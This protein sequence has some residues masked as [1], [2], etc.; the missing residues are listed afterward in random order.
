[1]AGGSFLASLVAGV[2]SDFLGRHKTIQ[3]S[4]FIWIVGAAIQCSSSTQAQL[5]VGRVVA[6]LGVGFASTQVPVYVAELSPKNIRGRLVGL[7]QFSVTIGILVQYAIAYGAHFLKTQASFRLAWGIQMVPGAFMMLGMIFTPES[8]R[9]LANKDRWEEAI[10]IV[11]Q[12]QGKGDLNNPQVLIEIEEL[13]EQVRIDRESQSFSFFDLF[14]KG[15][16][17]RT[18]VGISAQIWQQL[19]GMNVMMYYIVYIFMMAGYDTDDDLVPSIIQ[20]ALNVVMTIPA[21]LFIDKVGRRP[22]LLAGGVLMTLWL[23][24][25]TG[26]LAT[27]SHWVP[28]VGGNENINITISKDHQSASQAVIAC[29][30]L[31]V[32]SFAPTWGPGIWLYC[33]EIFPLKQRAMGSAVCG[34]FNWL[35]NFGIA[36]WTPVG[37]HNITWKTYIIYGCF[38]AAMTVHVFFMFPETSNK[39]LE[40]IEQIWDSGVPA[41]KSASFVPRRPSV[42]D[43]KAVS[44]VEDNK[45]VEEKHEEATV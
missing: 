38:S 10:E 23:F 16:L 2:V 40:E 29:C 4:A 28:S 43:I 12:V 17:R 15:N 41:W 3:I 45:A 24:A 44:G 9:W 34:S 11:S 32:C 30:Y 42:S 7:F 37:F 22:L 21:L 26:I 8:P 19:C 35:F 6:G 25:V 13:K 39:T 18:F 1:M 14:K 33:A 36:L 5:I 31:F 27:Y 20:Y